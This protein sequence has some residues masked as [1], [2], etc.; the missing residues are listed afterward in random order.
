MDDN[1]I[2]PRLTDKQW[3]IAEAALRVFTEKGFSAATTSEIAR[4]AGISEGTIFRHFKTK[5]EILLALLVPLIR[6]TMAPNSVNSI[7]QLLLNNENLPLREVLVLISEER[8]QFIWSNEKLIR[9]IITESQ[10]HPELREIFIREVAYKSQDVFLR[11]I[12]QRQQKGEIRRDFRPW[13]LARCWFGMLMAYTLSPFLL[14]ER[15]AGEDRQKELADMID[16]FLH[17]SLQPSG[18]GDGTPP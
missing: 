16:L 11:F 9:L 3:N 14:P 17:G 1:L 2:L 7:R 13:T 6:N 5:K 8:Q 18:S 15:V 10:Y 4:E 12:E